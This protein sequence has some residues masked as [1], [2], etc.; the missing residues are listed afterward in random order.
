M[1]TA[2]EQMGPAAARITPVFVSIDPA[3]DTPAVMKAYVENF[4]PRFIGLTGSDAEI[5]A[6]AKAYRVYY[7]K[8]AAAPGK[9]YT[10]DHPSLMYLMGPDG[11]FVTYFDYTTD[12]RALA[13]E[14]SQAI[15]ASP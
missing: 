3:R 11:R 2:L 7:G 6:I 8:S 4:G 10:M 13:G 9:D 12:A 15:A 5:A 14:L 1:A